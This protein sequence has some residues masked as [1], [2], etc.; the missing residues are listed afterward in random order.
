MKEKQKMIGNRGKGNMK[1]A[2]KE[3]DD[4]LYNQLIY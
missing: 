2:K 4:I 1:K 3:E